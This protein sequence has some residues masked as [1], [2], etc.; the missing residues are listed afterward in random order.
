M[1]IH[2]LFLFLWTSVITQDYLL[3]C[4]QF[5][6]H[7]DVCFH[8]LYDNDNCFPW[9]TDKCDVKVFFDTQCREL[10]CKVSINF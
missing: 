10:I 2:I 8:Y 1:K 5:T 3:K 6:I 4:S 9:K 7:A